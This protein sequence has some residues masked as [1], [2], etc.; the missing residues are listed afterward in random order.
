M[1]SAPGG[2]RGSAGAERGKGKGLDFLLFP[3]VGEKSHS[4]PPP[5]HLFLL[6]PFDPPPPLPPP[7]SLAG[8]SAPERRRAPPFCL[9]KQSHTGSSPSSLHNEEKSLVHPLCGRLQD[10]SHEMLE[11]SH[12]QERGFSESRT[13]LHLASF[14]FPF[15]I[16]WG[17]SRLSDDHSPKKIQFKK[18]F[19]LCP[20]QV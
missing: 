10:E 2:P 9:G 1:K 3:K 11:K 14:L 8:L 5:P 13:F 6:H 18:L 19:F 15:L 7:P 16:S 17:E 20:T 4:P 12:D